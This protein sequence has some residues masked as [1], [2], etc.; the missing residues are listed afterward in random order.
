MLGHL[1]VNVPD[2]SAA[3][4]YYG[5]LL[6]LVGFEP[7][8]A[9]A[10]EFSY[11]STGGKP[12]TYLFFYPATRPGEYSP[13]RTGLQHLAFS[14]SRRS[15]VRAVHAHVT[16]ILVRPVRPQA[17]SGLPPRPRLRRCGAEEKFAFDMRS[18]CRVDP[19]RSPTYLRA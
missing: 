18:V 14:V 15:S 3:K 19:V 10:D 11:R 8:F 4:R 17:R 2:L 16:A 7:F 1:G 13:R 12:G 9:A 6:P 5:A